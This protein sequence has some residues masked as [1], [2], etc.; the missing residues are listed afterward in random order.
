MLGFKSFCRARILI[1]GI[2]TIHMIREAQLEHPKGQ[3]S[4]AARSSTGW[5]FESTPTTP[6]SLPCTPL[7]RQNR[8]TTVA[9]SNAPECKDND[10]AS[11]A[12]ALPLY[13]ALYAALRVET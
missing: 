7:S 1:A 10:A 11:F 2:E 4:S 12:A 13:D 3:V 8:P 5:P 6:P 9:T